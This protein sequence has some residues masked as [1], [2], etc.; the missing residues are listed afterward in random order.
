M[1]ERIEKN[2]IFTTILRQKINPSIVKILYGTP[3]LKDVE[4]RKSRL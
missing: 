1:E 2:N 4:K 3:K